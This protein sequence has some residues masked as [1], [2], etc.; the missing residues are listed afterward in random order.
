MKEKQKTDNLFMEMV[1]AGLNINKEELKA[2]KAELAVLDSY[3]SV[4]QPDGFVCDNLLVWENRRTVDIQH[5]LST[6]LSISDDVIVDYMLRKGYKLVRESEGLLTWYVTRLN[7]HKLRVKTINYFKQNKG[8][9][10]M[11]KVELKA[12]KAEQ[13]VL[14]FYFKRKRPL[15]KMYEFERCR[16]IEHRKTTIDIQDDLRTTLCISEDVIV[17]YMLHNGYTLIPEEDGS[18][19]WLIYEYV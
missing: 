10:T 8:D 11:D 1:A 6:I 15:V 14:D 16:M 17:D 7:P 5:D 12:N 3:F 2:S 13:T 9:M 19:V 18:V 4:R